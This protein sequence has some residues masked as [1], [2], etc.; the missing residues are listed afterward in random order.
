[1]SQSAHNFVQSSNPFSARAFA[2]DEDAINP[3]AATAR[4]PARS[5]ATQ[6][7]DDA[8]PD[9][10]T[11]AMV[12][13]APDVPSEE[14]EL[15]STTA[16]EVTLTWGTSV[17]HVAHLPLERGFAVGEE[18][19]RGRASD[20]F[21]PEEKIGT[22]RLPLVLAG[23]K[24]VIPPRARGYVELPGRPRMTLDQARAIS[25]PTVEVNGAHALALARGARAR[26]EIGDFAFQLAAVAAGKPARRGLAT[27][28]DAAMA[29]FFGSSLL[30]SAAIVAS[31][32][33]FVPP[34]G[35]ADDE[36][37]Q[38]EQTALIQQYMTAAAEREQLERNE[39]T[40]RDQ[41]SDSEGGTGQRAASEEG[42]MGSAVATQQ[43][44]RWANQ[45]PKDNQDLQLS[46]HQM[47]ME[48]ETFGMIGLLNAGAAGS[49]APVVPFGGDVSLGNDDISAQGSMWGDDLGES[50]GTGGLGLTGIGQGGGCQVGSCVG[51]GL[52][53]IG[54]Y[55]HGS[56]LGTNQGFGNH[57]GRLGKG[58]KTKG[59]PAVRTS[60]PSVSGRLPAEV[61][62]RIVRQ[63]FGRFR[64]CYE[65]G[66]S[67]NPNLEGRIAARFVIGRD[68]AV[69]NVSNGGA[70]LADSGTLSCVL[71]AFYGLS[72]PQPEA[73]IVT[74]IYPIAFT[75]G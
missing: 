12:K 71:S 2:I 41:G 64:M 33:Y 57:H 67:R 60:P 6:V 44:R 40:T 17:L 43:N 59:A 75:P 18:Q 30:C 5:A 73:G 48:A 42:Q 55:G 50:R 70:D 29:G 15:A 53:S 56:G 66:L 37:A 58:Y 4:A 32:A 65:Q 23:G 31:L 7:A 35:L 49:D 61:I 69:S 27:S 8:D 47:R 39:P 72:F 22:T 10:Y 46:R 3:F 19:G 34:L 11:Y 1:M 36:G 20:Y 21:L 62:Q 24:I 38:R 52:G 63:N 28:F 16:I 9:T 74:V 26:I 54:T 14:V 25:E 13:S 45:G 68:G 51:I